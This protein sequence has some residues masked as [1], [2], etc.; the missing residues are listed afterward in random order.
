MDEGTTS[1]LPYFSASAA[2]PRHTYLS[3]IGG[4]IGQ[5]LPCA[6][7]AAVACPGRKVLALQADGSGMY[8]LQ[9]LWTQAREQLDVT[10]VICAN[11]SYRVLQIELARA[12]IKEPGPQA[13]ALTDLS[14]P[15]I[16]WV[17]LA[18]GISA[19][20]KPG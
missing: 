1:R 13:V 4:A 8:T 11:R 19:S 15:V 14:H 18:R 10:T 16:D 9:A 3:H 12:G 6:T 17:A 2:G 7:G 5:G 20:M